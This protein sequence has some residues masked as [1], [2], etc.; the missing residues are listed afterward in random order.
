[1]PANCSA[2]VQAVIGHFDK[3]FSGKNTSAINDLKAWLTTVVGRICL[4]LLRARRARPEDAAG[5]W[6][7]EPLVVEPTQDGPE[8][9]AEMA[10]SV[11]LALLVV[12]GVL[13]LG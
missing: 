10:D 5:A 3:V 2:D 13:L 1:M 9:Q 7:P 4:D 8:H 11:G 6:L 12:L